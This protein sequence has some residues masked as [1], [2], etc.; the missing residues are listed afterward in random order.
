MAVAD[1]PSP[2]SVYPILGYNLFRDSVSRPEV[3]G[4]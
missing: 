1:C 2:K 4:L 3:E